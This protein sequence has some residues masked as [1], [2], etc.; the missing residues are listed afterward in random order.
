MQQ[1][2][3]NLAFVL[4]RPMKFC[5]TSEEMTCNAALGLCCPDCGSVL[6]LA[7][8]LDMHWVHV[9]KLRS[10]VIRSKHIA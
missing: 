9:C 1:N 5:K 10:R 8:R 7:L 6:G 3:V 2:F 4:R